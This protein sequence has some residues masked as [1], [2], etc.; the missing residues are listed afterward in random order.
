MKRVELLKV[1]S[2]FALSQKMLVLLPNFS[3]PKVGWKNRTEAVIV[4]R[5]DGKTLEATAEFSLSHIN[6]RDPEVSIEK[7]CRI[8][9]W[10]TDRTK[11]EVPAGSTI[12]VSP[13]VR[14]ALLTQ[15][16]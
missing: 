11:E 5:P 7:R 3:V 10:L 4:A 9:V 12:L 6:I 15:K 14:D 13:E 8:A 1:E 16:K 2:A